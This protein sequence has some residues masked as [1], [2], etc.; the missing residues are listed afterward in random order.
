M[1]YKFHKKRFAGK[2]KLPFLSEKKIIMPQVQ[3]PIF[4]ADVKYINSNIGVQTKENDVYY[5]NGM[6]PIYHHNK[7]DYKSFRY[8]TSQMVV[9]GNAKQ[10]EIIKAFGV[11]KESVKRWVKVYRNEGST[12]FFGTKKGRRKGKVLDD[13]TIINA[14]AMLNV[15]KT[16]KEIEDELGIKQDTLRKAIKSGRLIKLEG[17]LIEPS[18]VTTKSDRSKE[19]SKAPMGVATTNTVGRIEAVTKKK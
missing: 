15:M 12:G 19:D 7:D 3:L 16:S 4:P 18:Q 13:Q 8:V 17:E 6:M 5:F 10:V 9:L 14:Q 2:R 1:F 11:S